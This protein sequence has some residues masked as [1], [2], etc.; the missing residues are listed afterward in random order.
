VAV[1]QVWQWIHQIGTV[2]KRGMRRSFW[3]RNQAGGVIIEGDRGGIVNN[4]KN[5]KKNEKK[6]KKIV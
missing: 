2:G 6:K 4:I 5:E 3:C 1:A